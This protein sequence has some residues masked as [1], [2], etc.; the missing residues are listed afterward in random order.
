MRPIRL[1]IR[2]S[3]V[4]VLLLL[5]LS[6]LVVTLGRVD[7]TIEATGEVGINNYLIVRPRVSGFV[8]EILVEPGD[9]VT[10]GQV[11]LRLEDHEFEKRDP[12]RAAGH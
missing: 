3:P 12:W 2:L 6:L 8:T 1:A 11:L 9:M 10:R 5:V 7:R 4:A